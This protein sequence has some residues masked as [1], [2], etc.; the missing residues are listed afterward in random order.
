[1]SIRLVFCFHSIFYFVIGFLI[2]SGCSKTQL[3]LEEYQ[4]Q[5]T[6]VLTFDLQTVKLGEFPICQTVDG[7]TMVIDGLV[8][9]ARPSEDENEDSENVYVFGL[10]NPGFTATITMLSETGRRVQFEVASLS[11]SN[12]NQFKPGPKEP[13]RCPV[14][15]YG[16]RNKK[17]IYKDYLIGPSYG[18]TGQFNTFHFRQRGFIDALVLKAESTG[19]EYYPCFDDF[20]FRVIDTRQ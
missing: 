10:G 18:N 20:V 5:I 16:L 2:S 4:K 14:Y 12:N 13:P 3:T 7:Y 19:K 11:V 9:K 6:K 17:D 8:P 1:M 15:A